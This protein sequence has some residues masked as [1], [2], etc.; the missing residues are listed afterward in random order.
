MQNI[1]SVEHR[2][3]TSALSM[4]DKFDYY[5]ITAVCMPGFVAIV[6]GCYVILGDITILLKELLQIS[7][8]SSI[9]L[10]VGCYCVGEIIQTLGKFFETIF[11]YV[12]R[13][14][15]AVWIAEDVKP[16][17]PKFLRK[18]ATYILPSQKESILARKLANGKKINESDITSNFY[19]IKLKCFENETARKELTRIISKANAIR[20]YFIIIL[21]LLINEIL[22]YDNSPENQSSLIYTTYIVLLLFCLYRYRYFS[23]IYAQT[24]YA[25]Y[26]ERIAKEFTHTS[27]P[28][29][30]RGVE[31]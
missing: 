5:D 4:K 26:C 10:C 14:R 29:R 31:N 17:F 11:W 27:A 30:A 19:S 2:F 21:G 6:A 20:G 23:I 1:I 16:K 22:R 8:G 12:Y 24:L 28:K 15:P 25:E 7:L 3:S 13:G 9:I 18:E